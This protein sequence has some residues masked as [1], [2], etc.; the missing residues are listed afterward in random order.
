MAV[1]KGRKSLVESNPEFSNQ[2]I[3][4]AVNELKIGWVAKTFTLDT[5][6]KNNNVL[7]NTQ[8][9]NARLTINN[10][11]HLNI[12]R[13]LNDML[14]HTNTILDGTV[15]PL[16][17]DDADQTTFLEILNLVLVVQDLV[18]ELLG[19]PASDKARDVNDH[20]GTINNKFLE[21][22]DSSLPVFTSLKQSIAFID[23]KAIAT[24]TAYQTALTNMT[25]FVDGV[26]GDSTDFQQ[27]LDTFATAVATAATN[28]NT[29]LAAEPYLTKRTQLIADNEAV[30]VQVALE[31][32]NL[33][34]IVTYT[35][36][37]NEY[38]SYTALA[39]NKELRTL[40]TRIS[41]NANFITYFKD[42]EENQNN[43][44]PVYTTDSDSDKSAVISQI[45]ADSGLPDVLD[46][47][48]FAAVAN[49]AKRDARI[50]TKNYDRLTVEQQITDA[51][52]QLSI[53]TANRSILNQSKSLLDNLNKRDRDLI[54]TQLDL[55]EEAS[56][57]S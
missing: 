27:T 39:E 2:N 33:S 4:N 47:T 6:I 48:D 10:Q 23:D 22:E 7:T 14:D 24:D 13:Y 40:I 26:V 3:E 56:T 28:F 21:T 36:S 50:D 5:S 25:N 15:V 53:T 51:C 54:A 17:E 30:D 38:N 55:N 31:K 29:A 45:L 41:Q 1:N 43:L 11:P 46:F 12:G 20:L 35:D 49:K 8:K 44:N 34:S 9:N 57:L 42:Y 19:V 37:L 16:T 52:K 18:P 32:S